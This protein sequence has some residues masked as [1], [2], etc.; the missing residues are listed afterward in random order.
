MKLISAFLALAAASLAAA[1]I[2]TREV[3]YPAGDVTARGFLAT[4]KE[5]GPH[6]G[7][8]VVHE[9]WGSNDYTRKRARMLAEMGYTALAVDMY[10]DGQTAE[11]PRDAGG[12]A[13]AVMNNQK[14]MQERFQGAMTFL[15]KQEEADAERIAAIGYCFGGNVVLQMARNGL[16]GLDGVASF[17][18][19]LN[20]R[21]PG[22]PQKPTAKVLVCNGKD[23]PFIKKEQI[24]AFKELMKASG[25][26]YKFINYEG[27]VHGFTNPGATKYGEKFGLPLAYHEAADK[28]SWEELTGF[29]QTLFQAAAPE[30]GG[31][32]EQ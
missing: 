26:D 15:Q 17:H 28:G 3:E 29:L 6:P 12:F 23:D 8:L 22:T 13:A 2:E 25:I 10:G 20:L 30:K 4:P 27:A 19:A 21:A 16:E 31:A 24:A 11:H 14:K 32:A 18:G 9:W 5:Q 1:E 7:V